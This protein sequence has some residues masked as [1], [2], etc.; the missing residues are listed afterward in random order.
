VVKA[1]T[2]AKRSPEWTSSY[3]SHFLFLWVNPLFVAGNDPSRP[4]LN[5]E[6]LFPLSDVDEPS[7]VSSKFEE[8]LHKHQKNGSKN[9]V[10][11]ALKEQFW[12]QI[13]WSGLVKALNSTLQFIPPVLLNFFLRWV[14]DAAY[15]RPINQWEGWMWACVLFVVLSC[16]TLTEN[17]YFHRVVRIGYQMRNAITTTVYRKSLRLSPVAKQDTPTGQIINLMQLDAT[18]ID[19][20]MLQFHVCW[21][22]LYQILGYMALLIYYLNVSALSG[23]AAL[24]ILIPLNGYAMVLMMKYRRSIVAAN[25]NRVK[26]TNETLQGIRAI[27]LYNWEEFFINKIIG[28][29][30]DELKAIRAYGV[31]SSYNSMLM[32]TAPILVSIITLMVFAGT[33]GDFSSATVFTAIAVLNSL[34]FPLMFYP[35]VI[36]QIADSKTSLDRLNKFCNAEEVG[37]DAKAD[38]LAESL[39]NAV[40]SVTDAKE[41]HSASLT[42]SAQEAFATPDEKV[43]VRVKGATFF[44]ENPEKRRER[45]K[46]KEEEEEK[47]RKKKAAAAAAAAKKSGANAS[48]TTTT[49]NPAVADAKK[50]SADSSSTEKKS[51][52]SLSDKPQAPAL[53]DIDFAIPKGQLWAVVGSVGCGKSALV[54]SI[55]GELSK[56]AN[57]GRVLVNG[58]IAYVPQS[59]WVLNASL[60]R[61]TTFAGEAHGVGKGMTDEEKEALYQKVVDVCQL[62]Q[63]LEQ[64]PSGDQTEIGERGINLS[65]GQ[66]QRVSIARAAYS[67]ADVFLFDDPLSALDAEVGK[68]IF[69]GCIRKHLAGKTRI[70][71]TNALQYLQDCD[72]II[73]LEAGADGVGRISNAGSFKELMSSVPAFASMMDAFGHKTE[74]VE[75]SGVEAQKGE[76]KSG[77]KTTSKASEVSTLA[78]K[79][80][81]GKTMMTVEDKAEGAVSGQV[82]VRYIRAGGPTVL[83]ISSIFISLVLNQFSQLASQWWITYWVKDKS[84]VDHGKDFYFGI[85]AFLGFAAALTSFVRVLVLQLIGVVASR[86]LHNNMLTSIL[87]APM[88]FFDTTPIGR[89]I[90]RFS[91]DMDSL[92]MMMP[93][94]LGM[95]WFCVF[96]IAGTFAAVIFATPWFAIA[97]IPVVIVYVRVMEYFRNVMREIK[98]MDSTTRSPIYALFSETLGGLSVIRAYGL[99]EDFSVQNEKLVSGNVSAWYTLKACDRWLSVRLEILGQV[100]VLLAALLAVGTSVNSRADGTASGLAGFSLSYAMAITGLLNWT[101]RTAAELEAQ[102][103]SVERVA[104]YTDNVAQEPMEKPSAT[105]KEEIV[106]AVWPSKGSIE[107]NKYKMKYRESTPEVLHGVSF[108][109]K[110]GEKVGVVGRT[111][112]GKSSLMVSL[113]RLIED[114]CHSGQIVIDGVD[115]D[116]IGLNTLRSALAIIPQEPV[117]FSGT[118]R[119]N[120]DPT[121]LA[122]DDAQIWQVLDRVG[123]RATV[124]RLKGGLDATVSEFGDSLSAGQR[125]LVCLARVLLRKCKIVLL[126]EATS[127]VDFATDA[128]MQS[129]IKE[130]FADATILVIAHRINTIIECDKILSMADGQ[131]AEYAH[132]HELLSAEGGDGIFKSLV[133]EL[134]PQTSEVLI[135]RAAACYKGKES[136]K[137][138]MVLR[139][140]TL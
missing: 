109:I 108:T 34:R 126:D 140:P 96:N 76:A 128:L 121:E 5:S 40:V 119:S 10:Y 120:V 45:L 136:E 133:Q 75:K 135:D 37:D 14:D 42:Q 16:R 48:S 13:F 51:P 92:D 57:G 105:R 35:M 38:A 102:A 86:N 117:L 49:T 85:F 39:G 88:A 124:E 41:T 91:K 55:L 93:Q 17:N 116:G 4:P 125:Q 129:V 29:R 6:D 7:L 90:A 66:K 101:V 52:S 19:S 54:S 87:R 9:A 115:I 30:N 59:A 3:L 113:C 100:I 65:G 67:D 73:W 12:G 8:L 60:K 72:G 25:D 24:L 103:T 31:Q 130:A 77:S 23:L 97:C 111:G 114:Q 80:D 107:F 131:V 18:R 63:D 81:A 20:M 104:Y 84:Y 94:Q 15:G 134:G 132:P 32:S 98:R 69:E 43:G 44:W 61:N 78:V 83:V 95:F 138:G 53:A 47:E 11:A 123:L 79:S 70:L 22:G 139:T 36:S 137:S 106:P 56:V 71:V 110:G 33:G 99:A 21:D 62:R 27:K 28:I 89:I 82:Y 74:A 118:L 64:L 46:F 122:K 68:A 2:P 26:V 58:R 50:S 112:S 127:S 1:P